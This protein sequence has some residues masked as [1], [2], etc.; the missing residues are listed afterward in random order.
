MN[1]I[2]IYIIINCNSQNDDEE[3]KLKSSSTERPS[4]KELTELYYS[5]QLPFVNRILKKNAK[6]K[7]FKMV[8]C[9]FLNIPIQKE[10]MSLTF[11]EYMVLC[12]CHPSLQYI[13]IPLLFTKDKLDSYY[14][15]VNKQRY[16]GFM[17]THFRNLYTTIDY[18]F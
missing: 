14:D 1:F 13:R 16:G 12:H 4:D 5:L 2:W 3:N 8:F 9:G 17:R 15:Q 11:L 18:F 10:E 7:M 6:M